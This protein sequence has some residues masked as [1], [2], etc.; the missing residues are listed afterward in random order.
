M[1]ILLN[2]VRK[3]V[4][5]VLKKIDMAEQAFSEAFLVHRAV[6]NQIICQILTMFRRMAAAAGER[7]VF[8]RHART[9]VRL[10][11]G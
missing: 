4:C 10:A 3:I 11:F 2:F 6:A 1:E 9:S 5:M 7:T 8:R